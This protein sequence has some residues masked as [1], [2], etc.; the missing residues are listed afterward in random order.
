M[1]LSRR[2]IFNYGWD[3]PAVMDY[4]YST[5]CEFSEIRKPF[6]KTT[7]WLIKSWLALFLS[8][9]ER[10]E[11]DEDFLFRSVVKNGTNP[12][13]PDMI[14]KRHIRPALK[15]LKI[16]KKIRWH[17]FRHGYSNFFR[18]N[19]LEIKTTQIL[20]RHANSRIPTTRVTQ[21]TATVGVT[22]R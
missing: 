22:T 15:R 17:S 20:L 14:L 9:K 10:I 21:E 2:S 3:I 19:K 8:T 13:T 4:L 6:T 5:S 11:C 12:I 7:L 16:A 18:E 1:R